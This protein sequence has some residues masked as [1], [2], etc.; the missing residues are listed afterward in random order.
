MVTRKL[1][2][3][4]VALLLGAC[5]E[6]AT[7]QG[8]TMDD[9][10]ILFMP[11]QQPSIHPVVHSPIFTYPYEIHDDVTGYSLTQAQLSTVRLDGI[12]GW[13]TQWKLD[14]SKAHQPDVY[15]LTRDRRDHVSGTPPWAEVVEISHAKVDGYLPLDDALYPADLPLGRVAG[16]LNIYGLNEGSHGRMYLDN[17]VPNRP[18]YESWARERMRLPYLPANF[19]GTA[20]TSEYAKLFFPRQIRRGSIPPPTPPSQ[21][22]ETGCTR[23]IAR[24]ARTW[25]ATVCG[26]GFTRHGIYATWSDANGARQ[27]RIVMLPLRGYRKGYGETRVVKIIIDG[28]PPEQ[29]MDDAETPD[30]KTLADLINVTVPIA[31]EHAGHMIV[32]DSRTDP[33][34]FR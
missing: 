34:E 17:R 20:L 2:A 21:P 24:G 28:T 12:D 10:A 19:E 3:L 9:G 22:T 25:T 31:A 32:I 6:A 33:R 30:G 18:E 11:K 15:F 26:S 8:R 23:T 4:G 27:V 16:M 1:F 29:G 7:E 13:F 5:G 14:R